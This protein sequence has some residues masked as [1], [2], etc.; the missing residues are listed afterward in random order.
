MGGG[1]R[2]VR[3]LLEV[4]AEFVPAAGYAGAVGERVGEERGGQVRD[5]EYIPGHFVGELREAGAEEAL[6][7]QLTV[8]NPARAFAMPVP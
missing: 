4:A 5:Y 2:A 8:E 7:R 1:Q 3:H 6:I